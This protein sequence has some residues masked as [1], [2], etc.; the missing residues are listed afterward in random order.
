MASAE[1]TPGRTI[2]GVRFL[3]HTA[4]A[5]IEVEAESLDACLARAA[6]GLF[7]LMFV[8]PPAPAPE[9]VEEVSAE[10]E[11]PEELLVVWLQELLYRS[12]VGSLCFCRFEVETD[13]LRLRGRVVGVP[14]GAGVEPVGPM[15]KAVTRHDL[16]LHR[17]GERWRAHVL[18][19]V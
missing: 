1:I 7:A 6:A 19:D 10:A 11:S 16:R 12:E 2:E 17:A 18:V 13:G 5:G 15:V 4:D 9:Q 3:E 8:P 14:I